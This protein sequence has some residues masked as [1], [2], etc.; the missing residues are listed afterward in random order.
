[1]VWTM[2]GTRENFA[3]QRARIPAFELWVWTISNLSFLKSL[4][5][6]TIVRRSLNGS[7]WRF[8]VG[9]KYTFTSGIL[10]ASSIRTPSGEVTKDRLYRA[11]GRYL[12]ISR[13]VFWAP[14]SSSLVMQCKTFNFLKIFPSSN[15]SGFWT[16]SPE[17]DEDRQDLDWVNYEINDL[18]IQSGPS[19]QPW[20]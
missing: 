8:R 15:E 1:M 3:A 6:L 13:V 17:R 16:K 2:I 18:K 7:I 12:R 10:L 19:M 5:K 4:Y 9:I 11:L 20:I 14:P